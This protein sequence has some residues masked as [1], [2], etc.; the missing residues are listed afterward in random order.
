MPLGDGTVL[1]PAPGDAGAR[2]YSPPLPP[3]QFIWYLGSLSPFLPT[4]PP[5]VPEI[6][7]ADGEF[8]LRGDAPQLI[9]TTGESDKLRGKAVYFVR[10]TT[11]AV[12]ASSV[13]QDITCGEIASSAL[14]TFRA[15]VMDLFLPILKEQAHPWGK[16]SEES[17]A[18]F[19]TSTAKF[20]GTLSEAVNSLQGGVELRKPERKYID[21]IELSPKG[22]TKAAADAEVSDAFET[23]I[24]DWCSQVERLLEDGEGN[25]KDADDA[26]PDTEL[27]FWRN[28]MAKFN[29][30]T[31][32]LKTKECRL[33]L[34]VSQAGRGKGHRN[35]K[36]VDMKVG[37]GG[38]AFLEGGRGGALPLS[39]PAFIFASSCRGAASPS[40]RRLCVNSLPGRLIAGRSHAGFFTYVCSLPNICPPPPLP[41][42]CRSRTRRT[43]PRTTSST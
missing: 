7:T 21:S 17:T 8:V 28:R 19:M 27:E 34:G 30:I 42:C 33:V 15:L 43:R 3:S 18:E 37:G 25:R 11:K 12:N 40:I 38:G 9:L 2:A 26:G 31:E 22:F 36:A 23:I 29:S 32:Q 5:Q 24:D 39:L 6:E 4:V 16:N 41:P 14:D 10:A 20:A 1:L 13:E 35:W